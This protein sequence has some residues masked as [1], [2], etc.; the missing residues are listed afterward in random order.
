MTAASDAKRAR[1]EQA[2]RANLRRRKA[3]GTET[4]PGPSPTPAASRREAL[5]GAPGAQGL[6]PE[7]AS[8]PGAPSSE[9]KP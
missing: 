1:L 9:R 2:L 3:A 7:T 6:Y 8:D 5:D 4:G